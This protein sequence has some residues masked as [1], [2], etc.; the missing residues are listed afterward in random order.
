MRKILPG[1]LAGAAPRCNDWVRSDQFD[2]KEKEKEKKKC[3]G[4][5]GRPVSIL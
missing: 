5:A 4:W 2:S 1:D 3:V